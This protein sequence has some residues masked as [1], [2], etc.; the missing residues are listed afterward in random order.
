MCTIFAMEGS[1]GC[2]W[3]A[4]LSA[5]GKHCKGQSHCLNIFVCRTAR[6]SRKWQKSHSEAE[7]PRRAFCPSGQP[8]RLAQSLWG[9]FRGEEKGAWQ[10]SEEKPVLWGAALQWWK[11]AISVFLATTVNRQFYP[12]GNQVNSSC[13]DFSDLR[14]IFGG[15]YPQRGDWRE[16]SEFLLLLLTR[17]LNSPAAL[18]YATKTAVLIRNSTH[19]VHSKALFTSKPQKCLSRPLLG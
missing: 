11:S 14:L 17:A 13:R 5:Q 6:V 18:A 7:K 2:R 3:A 8:T 10:S 4:L 16:T 19:T 1:V 15:C 9:A 12:R